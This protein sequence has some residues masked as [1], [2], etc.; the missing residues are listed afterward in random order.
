MGSQPCSFLKL[1]L[2]VHLIN[3][4]WNQSNLEEQLLQKKC[5]WATTKSFKSALHFCVILHCIAKHAIQI[6][7]R[8]CCI[9]YFALQQRN[10]LL[11]SRSVQLKQNLDFSLG[12]ERCGA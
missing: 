10:A 6:L 4:C 12:G 8:I 3:N 5:D 9:A 11:C 7:Y 2:C 1:F